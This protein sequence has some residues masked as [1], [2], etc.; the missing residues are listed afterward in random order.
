M[1]L[2]SVLV[3]EGCTKQNG[4]DVF[5]CEKFR[6]SDLKVGEKKD[7]WESLASF[8]FDYIGCFSKMEGK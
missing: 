3:F 6:M 8:R 5:F 2:G 4:R 1:T 7:S